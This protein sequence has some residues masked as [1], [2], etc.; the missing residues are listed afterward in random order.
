[1]RILG[2]ET[3]CDECSAAVVEDGTRVLSNHIATQI[4][5]HTPWYGVVPEIAS[6]LHTE[7]IDGVVQLAMKEAS[8]RFSDLDGIAVT[9]M[10]GLM[11]SLLVGLSYAKALSWSLDLPL[12]S[13]N[14]IEAHLYAPHLEYTIKYPYL[15]LVVSGGHTLICHVH[16]ARNI[17][18]MGTTV[19]D[20]CGEAFDKVA[21]YYKMGYPGGAVIDKLS[22]TGNPRAYHFPKAR[23]NK[24]DHPFDLSY[25]GLKTAVINQLQQFKA[26]NTEGDSPEDIAASFQRI[27]IEMLIDR[28]KLAIKERGLTRVVAG[29]GVSAN[30]YL[31]RRLK[32]LDNVEAYFPSMKLCTDNGAMIA[33][34]GYRHFLDGHFSGLDANA[35]A[36]VS[37]FKHKYP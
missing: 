6:R 24:G 2:I 37:A 26:E 11:G 20:A 25:S 22:E 18:V 21:K 7:W 15:G 36:R 17:E 27:A 4:D 33:G 31:R 29:G 14:H 13:V 35:M 28:V 8:C 5:E 32:N 30:S 34:L 19:D 23:L 3:S 10:P 16:D 12:V 9:A 1:M